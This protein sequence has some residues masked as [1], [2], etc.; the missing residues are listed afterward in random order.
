MPA[1]H[2]IK[3]LEKHKLLVHPI[4]LSIIPVIT[5]VVSLSYILA[6][7]L[8]IVGF[9]V[10]YQ[11]SIPK[12]LPV[13]MN[14]VS[15]EDPLLFTDTK[16][17]LEDM[18]EALNYDKDADVILADTSDVEVLGVSDKDATEYMNKSNYE[19]TVA[20]VIPTE[21]KFYANESLQ[22]VEINKIS[23]SRSVNINNDLLEYILKIAFPVLAISLSVFGVNLLHSLNKPIAGKKVKK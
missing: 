5:T 7:T 21:D 11:L 18:D 9:N 16:Y 14:P 20:P 10:G 6:F 12:N 2:L 17:E 3:R 13:V 8:C 23:P 1:K 22:E 15:I 4:S 19:T